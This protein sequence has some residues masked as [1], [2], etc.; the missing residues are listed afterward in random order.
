MEQLK[1]PSIQA[2]YVVACD[3]LLTNMMVQSLVSDS[4]VA[5]SEPLQDIGFDPRWIVSPTQ[6]QLNDRLHLA[7]IESQLRSTTSIVE[8]MGRQ[9]PQKYRAWIARTRAE[10]DFHGL[11]C[12]KL[13]RFE[14]ELAVI[15][16]QDQVNQSIHPNLILKTNVHQWLIQ[17]VGW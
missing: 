9:L 2:I 15:V 12:A 11:N 6:Q 7:D 10:L 8:C 5:M 14:L 3:A 16:P 17:P 1:I 4:I 13:A